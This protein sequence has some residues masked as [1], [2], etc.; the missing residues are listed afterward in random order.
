MYCSLTPGR[1]CRRIGEMLVAPA[2]A[3][4]LTTAS[5][6]SGRSDRPGRTGATSTPVGMPASFSLATASTRFFGCGVPGSVSF[7][8]SSSR[9]PI[10]AVV[11]DHA[12]G[13]EIT[14]ARRDVIHRHLDP[15]IVDRDDSKLRL[16]L[17]RV[18]IDGSLPS[19]CRINGKEEAKMLL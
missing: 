16:V 1:R 9:V 13:D 8:T 19:G 14:G 18:A 2:S 3:Q 12:V 10:E 17:D 5:S 4:A 15:E 6:C 11:A 7:H